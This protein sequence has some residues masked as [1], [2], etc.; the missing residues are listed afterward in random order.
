MKALC[1]LDT[2]LV[3]GGKTKI[4]SPLEM[5]VESVNHTRD[6]ILPLEKSKSGKKRPQRENQT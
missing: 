3:R 1:V 2:S 6:E 5:Y 4:I